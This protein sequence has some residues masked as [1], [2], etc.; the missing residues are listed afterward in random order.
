MFERTNLETGFENALETDGLRP[1]SWAELSARFAAT[2]DLRRVF[3]A[4]GGQSAGNFASFHSD[5]ATD[6][7]ENIRSVNLDALGEHKNNGSNKPDTASD[8]TTGDREL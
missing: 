6:L 2:H 4:R 1:L 3:S 8:V 7:N 5:T